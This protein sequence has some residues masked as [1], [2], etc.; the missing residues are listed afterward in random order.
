MSLSPVLPNRGVPACMEN[1]QNDDTVCFRAE[2]DV[3]RESLGDDTANILVN[4]CVGHRPLS[5][6]G[7]TSFDFGYEFDAQVLPFTLVP[8]G[9]SMNSARAE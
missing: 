3:K 9:R 5:G 2:V 6:D 8:C 4:C 1:G 7:H